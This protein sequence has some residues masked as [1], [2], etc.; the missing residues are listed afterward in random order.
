MKS[1]R[2][3]L[4]ALA[5]AFAVT[6]WSVTAQNVVK[7]EAPRAK[8][9]TVERVQAGA[10]LLDG[11]L[12]DAVWKQATFHSDFEQKGND[13]SYPPRARTEVAFLRDDEALYVAAR[14]QNDVGGAPRVL[15]GRRD[16]VGNAER[17]L[18]SLD[19][20]HDHTTAY[21]FGVTVGG[22][23]IDHMHA[24]DLE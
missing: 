4:L 9:M 10:V 5:A 12:D 1:K 13:R 23:R 7:V 16:D 14:M 18:V 19:T 11:R 24:R 3:N 22:V 17:F 8:N 20:H 2:I 6:P 15:L 21:T